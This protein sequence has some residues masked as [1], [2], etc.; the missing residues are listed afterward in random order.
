MRIAII[1]AGAVGS[2][3]GAS[4]AAVGHSVV[5]VGR[6][7]LVAAVRER[8]LRVIDR[9]EEV[10]RVD[11]RSTPPGG[12]ERPEV[13][14]LA[15]KAFDL[16]AALEAL[17]RADPD[18]LP[19]LLLQNG[20]GIERTA[21]EALAKAGWA[22]PADWTVRA[23]HTVAGTLVEPG[24]VRRA[25]LGEVLLA[26]PTNT[27]ANRPTLELF[28]RLLRGAGLTV[29]TVD[30]LDREIWR[31]ALVNA[32]INPVTALRGL[33]NG[34][35][36]TGPARR[37]ALALLEEARRAASAVGFEFSEDEARRDFDR[38][39]RAT[40]EN[41]SSMLQDLDRGRPTEI[42][43]ISG[44]ILRVAVE[45][46]LDLPATRRTAEE[47]RRRTAVSLGRPQP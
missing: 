18:P 37:E 22:A 7:A 4:L 6:S 44:A 27:R 8:G 30:D 29:R 10:Y 23:V 19:V 3:F 15:V 21:E 16:A 43:A 2:L 9:T 13:A 41:R 34:A 5:L 47:V 28:E 46:G 45:H 31:K 24:V 12:T 20:L 40:A 1:G 26:R 11:A 39:V 33:P 42:D 14:L 38:V 17:A 36:E 32:A 25:G 35:L